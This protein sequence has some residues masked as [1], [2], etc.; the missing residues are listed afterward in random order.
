MRSTIAHLKVLLAAEKKKAGVLGVL[1]LMLVVVG[2]RATLQAG[3]SKARA[4]TASQE[5]R[6]AAAA[7][8][9][10][11]A[12][13]GNTARRARPPVTVERPRPLRRDLFLL[14]EAYFPLPSQTEPPAGMPPKSG[15]SNVEAAVRKP[16]GPVMEQSAEERVQKEAG[17]LRLRGTLIGSTPM[18]VIEVT[19][20]R[21]DKGNVVRPGQVVEGFTL[22]EVQS[23]GVVLEKDGVRVELRRVLPEG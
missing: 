4:A 13:S 11:K 21:A 17:S 15:S 7:A 20:K 14:S 16:A 1:L 9:A 18:A 19:G 23:T 2:V 8:E 10:E 3:P 5:R 6:A 22:I 12:A